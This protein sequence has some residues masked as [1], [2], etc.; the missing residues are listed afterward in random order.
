MNW[1]DSLGAMMKVPLPD[2]DMSLSVS[3]YM[4]SLVSSFSS[5]SARAP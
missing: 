2:W 3:R 4:Y 1:P 5:I